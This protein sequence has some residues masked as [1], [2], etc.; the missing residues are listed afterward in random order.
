MFDSAWQVSLLMRDPAQI[1]ADVHVQLGR[2][3]TAFAKRN[4]LAAVE[5][6]LVK[7]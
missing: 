7:L 1:A 3:L 5:D 2:S 6:W 4:S